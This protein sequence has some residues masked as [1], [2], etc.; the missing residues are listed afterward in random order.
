MASIVKDPNTKH[1]E[2][3]PIS[4]QKEGRG[5]MNIEG[6][7]P[8]IKEIGLAVVLR[9]KG[10]GKALEKVNQF[11]G[12]ND[13]VEEARRR[14]APLSVLFHKYHQILEELLNI[15]SKINSTE[16]SDS[17]GI[18][19]QTEEAIMVVRVIG[20][21]QKEASKKGT[22]ETKLARVVRM[23]KEQEFKG[24]MQIQAVTTQVTDLVDEL[25]RERLRLDSEDGDFARLSV[26]MVTLERW[27]DWECKDIRRRSEL[28]MQDRLQAKAWEIEEE[29]RTAKREEGPQ[30]KGNGNRGWKETKGR[31]NLKEKNSKRN[32]R[33]VQKGG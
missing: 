5:L 2:S 23:I 30:E 15:P 9:L 8:T 20:D 10:I 19:D 28:R 22:V 24:L 29:C 12:N 26:A 25:K 16:T 31:R 27:G 13:Q 3:I 4:S 32:R 6:V 33:S 14:I 1:L 7:S 17:K 11:Y 18:I 21:L